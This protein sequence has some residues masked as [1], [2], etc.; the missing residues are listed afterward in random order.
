MALKEYKPGAAFSGVI[1]RTFMS[2][3]RRGRSRCARRKARPMFCLSCSMTWV[4]DSSAASA[5][6]ARRPTWMPSQRTACVTTTCTRPR[7]AVAL[8]RR[9]FAV[10]DVGFVCYFEFK[11]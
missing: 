1:G 5:D 11:P 3:A 9:A 7:Y 10:R 4:S 6:P 2:P 8:P